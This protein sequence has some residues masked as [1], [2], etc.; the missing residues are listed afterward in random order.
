[1][2]QDD[3]EKERKEGKIT[4]PI[5]RFI[6]YLI[7]PYD[8]VSISSIEDALIISLADPT[9]IFCHVQF[10]EINTGVSLR[11]P[12]IWRKKDW[13]TWYPAE[14]K[15]KAD[16]AEQRLKAVIFSEN[17]NRICN[18][19]AAKYN[20][21]KESVRNLAVQMMRNPNIELIVEQLGITIIGSDNKEINPSKGDKK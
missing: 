4:L 7:G 6:D 13:N 18:A 5:G 9:E 21:D 1:M 17:V 2:P 19:L 10:T 14:L 20:L 16:A 12:V 15:K 8:R 3:K 11:N